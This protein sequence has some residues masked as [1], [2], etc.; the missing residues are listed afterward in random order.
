MLVLIQ[1][2][3]VDG[4]SAVVARDCDVF[5]SGRSQNQLAAG[6]TQS[7]SNAGLTS[8]VV[9]RIAKRAQVVCIGDVNLTDRLTVHAHGE[10]V[11]A[12][13]VRQFSVG[14]SFCFNTGRNRNV[15]DCCSQIFSRL[16]S[17]RCDRRAAFWAADR[18][19]RSSCD[20]CV[21]ASNGRNSSVQSV[22]TDCSC[23]SRVNVDVHNLTSVSTD[24]ELFTSE[25]TVDDVHTVEGG[26]RSN[27]VDFGNQL[28]GLCRKLRT[29]KTSVCVVG[30]L[31]RQLAKTLQH[32]TN[33][34]VRTFCCVQ[35]VLRVSGVTNRLVQTHDLRSHFFSNRHTSRVI[36]SSI[37]TQ[38]RRQ[39]SH[40][41]F[42][43]AVNFAHCRLS[44]DGADVCIDEG[45]FLISVHLVR[46]W[47][48]ETKNDVR[49]ICLEKN[50]NIFQKP[51][52]PPNWGSFLRL[53]Y[54]P[55]DLMLSFRCFLVNDS[56]SPTSVL[57]RN[58]P[59]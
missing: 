52:F 49:Q 47:A 9:D 50:H 57:V 12:R 8:L 11:C 46:R 54:I 15:V 5:A 36:F 6:I 38:T 3:H 29:V 17:S 23:S 20:V 56:R 42:E 51:I 26:V 39:A 1:R 32:V 14:N 59:Y 18:N 27:A 35:Q 2:F 48:L 30:R 40:C 19:C 34:L 31:N 21:S 43:F 24:L 4:C 10:A 37:D 16:T 28:V 33:F 13:H 45:H 41:S 58:L 22:C 25:R 53:I 55:R 7:C 44:S